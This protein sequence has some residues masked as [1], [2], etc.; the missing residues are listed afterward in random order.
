MGY[1]TV[2]VWERVLAAC[3]AR[4]HVILYGPAGTGKTHAGINLGLQGREVYAVTLD[5]GALVSDLRGTYVVRDNNMVWQDGPATLAARKGARLV[6]NEIDRASTEVLSFLYG[7]CDSPASALFTLPTGEVVR[8]RAGFQA[9]ATMNGAFDDL[10]EGLRSRFAVRVEVTEIAPDAIAA[11]PEDL[12][13]AAQ[14][15]IC[16]GERRVTIREWH[17]FAD[18]RSQVSAELA[19]DLVFAAA[20]SDVLDSLAA[21]AS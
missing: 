13:A 1:L 17:A 21:A 20:A 7:L 6:I 5:D 11:L 2:G 14:S 10:P 18:L 19:A 3:N 4:S 12:Q 15:S 9:L 8:P 16:A